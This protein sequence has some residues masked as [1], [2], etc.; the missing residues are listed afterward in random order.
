MRWLHGVEPGRH[1]GCAW[2]RLHV[3]ADGTEGALPFAGTR[4]APV[5]H[6]ER[7]GSTGHEHVEDLW[8]GE[9]LGAYFMHPVTS[10][11]GVNLVGLRAGEDYYIA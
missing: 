11:R 5:D 1:S 6:H 8:E 7:V 10:V 3:V 2:S 9:Q 4:T